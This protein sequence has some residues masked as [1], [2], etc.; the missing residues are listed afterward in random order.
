MRGDLDGDGEITNKD[1]VLLFRYVSGT[2]KAEDETVYD[3]DGDGNVDNKDVVALF[4]YASSD[5]NAPK[6]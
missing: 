6:G 3:F 2:E 4:R 5:A 1:V